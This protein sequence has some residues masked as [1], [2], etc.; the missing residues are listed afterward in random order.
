MAINCYESV[1]K[2]MTDYGDREKEREKIRQEN[3]QLLEEFD[4]WLQGKQLTE[5]TISKHLRNIDFYINHFLLYDEIIEAKDG[6]GGI[7]EFLGD[8]FIR[9]A[10]WSSVPQI[11]SNVASLKKFYKF[12]Y[13]KGLTKQKD[14]DLLNDVIREY[15]PDW[16]AAMKR[17][18]M[19]LA[20]CEF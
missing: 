3:D 15:M 10:L 6:C 4:L 9:K 19:R 17:F 14:L 1:G 16:I 18:D 8:W 7:C 13:E 11:K 12:M 2:A 5:A 20:N